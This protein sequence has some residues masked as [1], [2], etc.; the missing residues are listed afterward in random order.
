MTSISMLLI[1]EHST[2][3]ILVCILLTI[4]TILP[5]R[6]FHKILVET[7]MNMHGSRDVVIILCEGSPPK[8]T[9]GIVDEIV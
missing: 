2:P 3:H 8:N 4:Y 6:H 5:L 1:H 7:L 9:C